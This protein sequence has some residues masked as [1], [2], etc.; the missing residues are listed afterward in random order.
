MKRNGTVTSL[1]IVGMMLLVTMICIPPL[2]VRSME[3]PLIAPSYLQVGDLLFIESRHELGL[4]DLPGWDHIAMY[5]G[6]NSYFIESVPYPHTD[7]VQ[8]TSMF[9]FTSW[10]DDVAFGYVKTASEEQRIQAYNFE[11]SQLGRPWQDPYNESWYANADPDD[12]DDPY[13]DEWMC[14]EIVWAA[15]LH[16]GI[17]I[18][19]TPFPPPPEEGGDGIHLYVAPQDIAD[20][21]DVALYDGGEPPY[22]PSKPSGPTDVKFLQTCAYTTTATDPED[23]DIYYQWDWGEYQGPWYLVPRKSGR[24]VIRPHTWLTKGDHTVRVRAKDTFGNVGDWSEPLMVT[25]SE[26]FGDGGGSSCFL[27]GSQVKMADLSLKNIEDINVGDMVLSYDLFNQTLEP[28]SVTKVYHHEPEEMPEYYLVINDEIRVTPNHLLYING[29]LIQAGNVSVGDFLM[30]LNEYFIPIVSIEPVFE[31]VPTYNFKID[32]SM[33][34][35]IIEEIPV[36]Y[37]TKPGNY[38]SGFSIQSF[39]Y[40]MYNHYYYQQ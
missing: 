33:G 20:D 14:S 26:W 15:Y 21:D 24:P 13:S 16:Q 3:P 35:Y 39:V 11:V 30:V 25:V 34:I 37:P 32:T 36:A 23:D 22:P 1:L 12:P 9:F 4:Q 27:A 31:Q 7:G 8:I 17:N 2:S 28:A 18:D 38:Q 10:A 5:T 6:K 19:V 40:H 29:T